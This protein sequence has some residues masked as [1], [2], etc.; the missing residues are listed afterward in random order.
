MHQG[1]LLYHWKLH[2]PIVTVCVTLFHLFR[3]EN[4]ISRFEDSKYL[5]KFKKY[6]LNKLFYFIILSNYNIYIENHYKC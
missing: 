5:K 6:A 3:K 4:I 1:Y 2:F